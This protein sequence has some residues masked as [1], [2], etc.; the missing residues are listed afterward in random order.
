MTA[1]FTPNRQVRAEIVSSSSGFVSGVEEASLLFKLHNIKARAH[2]RDGQRL[3]PG[4]LVFTLSGKS[5]DILVVERIALNLLSRMSA[6]TTATRQ[7]IDALRGAKSRAKIAATRKTSPGFMRLE[8]KAVALGG[9]VTHRMGLYDM[10]LVKDNHLMLFGNDVKK[11]LDAA[12]RAR[13]GLKVEVEVASV[14][15]AVI[16]AENGADI[17]M[18]DNMSPK[19][20]RTAVGLL[21][22]CGLRRKVLLEVSGGVTLKNLRRYSGLDVDWISTSKLTSSATGLDFTLHIL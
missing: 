7:Y 15:D 2:M 10:I 20:I 6:V 22:K 21:K 3:R 4:Q 13:K 12:N 19:Q 17:V 1:A 18:F 9:G 11:A 16:A 14:R 5:R 8:K